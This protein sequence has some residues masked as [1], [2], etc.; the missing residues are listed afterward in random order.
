MDK[1]GRHPWRSFILTRCSKQSHLEKF[2]QDHG[3]SDKY[4][5][6]EDST[7]S[8]DKLPVSDHSHRKKKKTNNMKNLMFTENFLYCSLCPSPLVLTLD[9]TEVWL[10]R[11]YTWMHNVL[12][13]IDHI[14]LSLLVPGLNDPSLL[15]LSSCVRCS[16]PL[17][18]FMA[19][20]QTCS[21][22][23]LFLS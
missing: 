22:M 6:G 13:H 11:L 17:I 4:L 18:T 21:N 14:H 19:F 9:T 5:Q 1:V 3:Q 10:S 15:F 2:A 16:Y 20:C 8:L 7:T 23:S 12:V